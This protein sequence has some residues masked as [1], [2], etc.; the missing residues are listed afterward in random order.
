MAKQNKPA[1]ADRKAPCPIMRQC[2]G[3]EW[4]GLP[5]RKQLARKQLAMSDLY[6]PLIERFGWRVDVDPVLGIGPSRE[7]GPVTVADAPLPAPRSFRHKA[8]TP[9]RPRR[10]WRSTQRFLR[11]GNARYRPL[12]RLRR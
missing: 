5:Y 2:G 6:R 11:P 10:M 4:L 8:A 1:S 12:P 3:C 9:F 7:T